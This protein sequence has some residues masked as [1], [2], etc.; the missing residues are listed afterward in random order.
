MGPFTPALPGS[1]LGEYSIGCMVKEA[2]TDRSSFEAN[3][4]LTFKEATC[5]IDD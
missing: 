3:T 5:S 2:N 4:G 1:P